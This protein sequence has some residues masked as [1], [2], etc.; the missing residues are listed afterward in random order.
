[1]GTDNPSPI[2][3]RNGQNVPNFLA[4][5]PPTLRTAQHRSPKRACTHCNNADLQHFRC[6]GAAT[7]RPPPLKPPGPE[8]AGPEPPRAGAAAAR[9]EIIV[10]P[11]SF[12]SLALGMFC[13]KKIYQSF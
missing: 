11:A 6:G 4:F 2:F 9:P 1:M 13:H 5:A 3:S 10:E 7:S 8:P 12:A